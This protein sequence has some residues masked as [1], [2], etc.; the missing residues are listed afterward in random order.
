TVDELPLTPT[1]KVDLRALQSIETAHRPE[2]AQAYEAPR[3]AL[4]EQ[5]A[6]IW[7]DLLKIDRVG[8]HDNFFELGGHSLLATQVVSRVREELGVRLP[9]G[10]L[11]EAPTLAG[12]AEAYWRTENRD[13]ESEDELA[14]LMAEMEDLSDEE[15]ERL[16]AAEDGASDE[17][18]S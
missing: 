1:G 9:L 2:Q 7:C 16:L 8:I 10:L 4:E 11:F 18:T 6:A 12:L 17:S 3:D 15:I 5:L 13:P 14:E